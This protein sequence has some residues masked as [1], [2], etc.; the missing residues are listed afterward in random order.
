MPNPVGRPTKYK[1]EYCDAIIK[2]FTVT[3]LIEFPEGQKT[4]VMPNKLPTFSDFCW[5]IGI[6]EDTMLNW[7]KEHDEF[8]GAYNR[9][10]DLQKQ[11]LL[12]V[13]LSGKSPPAFA[14]FTAK[15]ITDM[16]DQSAIDLTTGGEKLTGFKYVKPDD[17][18]KNI[19]KE[20]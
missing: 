11:F 17:L 13:G 5:E 7:T 12:T 8:L 16:K 4:I 2:H 9:A 14:I 18:S 10:K 1:P 3:P 6:S 20:G 15:N 19:S